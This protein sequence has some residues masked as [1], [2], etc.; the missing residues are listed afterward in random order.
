MFA[1]DHEAQSV[2]A[3]RRNAE[4]N[5][6]AVDALELDL[7]TAAPPPAP[8]VAANVPPHVHAAL[9]ARLP[10]AVVH[11]IASGFVEHERDELLAAYA[12]A[13]LAPRA[14]LGEHGGVLLEREVSVLDPAPAAAAGPATASSPRDCRAAGSRLSCHKLLEDGAR[15]QLLIAPDS[16]GST[17]ARRRTVAGDH[18]LRSRRADALGREPAAPSGTTAAA[19]TRR[20]SRAARRLHVPGPSWSRCAVLARITILSTIDRERGVTH[21]TRP[22]RSCARSSKGPLRWR[23]RA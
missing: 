8:T 23:G 9:A 5:G 17:C 3:A 22:T 19:P 1:V 14:Q 18:A 15:G 6:V 7:A 21:L 4:R 10:P 2:A 12:A 16:S 20:R 13:G 11:L